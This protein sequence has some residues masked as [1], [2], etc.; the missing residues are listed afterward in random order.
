MNV[1][2]SQY[3]IKFLA[4][5][6]IEV[7]LQSIGR[8]IIANKA[9]ESGDS[10]NSNQH[11]TSI[12]IIPEELPLFVQCM[13]G[14]SEFYPYFS[15]IAYLLRVF[16]NGFVYIHLSSGYSNTGTYQEYRFDFPNRLLTDL[17]ERINEHMKSPGTG[18]YSLSADSI[19]EYTNKVK[20]KIQWVY[21]HRMS[22]KWVHPDNEPSYYEERIDKDI[23]VSLEKWGKHYP[24][25]L[26]HCKTLERIAANAS[27]FGETITIE[28]SFDMY[29]SDVSVPD[30]YYFFIHD[31]K[32]N[33]V[34]NGG[35]IA[36][37][38]KQDNTY[39][40]STHT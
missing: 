13:T 18:E 7:C 33:R 20:P 39:S 9:I 11:P 19:L 8:E 5:G 23:I 10:Y 35:I 3:C 21:Q 2:V 14:E 34:M 29:N 26:D 22:G 32:G 36:H 40:Y 4:S 27:T 1:N 6:S 25:L 17:I 37:Y 15:D 12:I 24:G 31:D 30:S 28:L 16:P 38:N